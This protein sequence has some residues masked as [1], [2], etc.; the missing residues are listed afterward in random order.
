ME[1]EQDVEI[2]GDRKYKIRGVGECI[3]CGKVHHVRHDIE[4]MDDLF[5]SYQGYYP[6]ECR[7]C[8]TN[9]ATVRIYPIDDT[10]EILVDMVDEWTKDR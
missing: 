4:H 1:K 8:Q 7:I 3:K 10:F 2:Y 5:G 6:F 9:D